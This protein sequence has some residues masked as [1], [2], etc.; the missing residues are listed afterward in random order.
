MKKNEVIASVPLKLML[1]TRSPEI[2][3]YRKKL[4][5]IKGLSN[6]EKEENSF[7][8]WLLQRKN[9]NTKTTFR[10]FMNSLPNDLS[11]MPILFKTKKEK[12]LLYTSPFQKKLIDNE[13][14][15]YKNSYKILKKNKLLPDKTSLY[16]YIEAGKLYESRNFIQ[17]KDNNE[18]KGEDFRTLIPLLDL[19]NYSHQTNIVDWG[20]NYAK[21]EFE[22]CARNAIKNGEQVSVNYLTV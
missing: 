13:R 8:L 5:N 12:E 1:Y 21:K 22:V 6:N 10:Y 18:H 2:L 4:E 15:G 14:E 19:F 7:Y 20:Y 11:T 3:A 9:K 16:D 17:Y